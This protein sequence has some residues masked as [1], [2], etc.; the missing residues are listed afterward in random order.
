[1]GVPATVRASFYLYNDLSEVDALVSGVREAQ[2][3]FGVA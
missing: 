2:R 3:F 1:M